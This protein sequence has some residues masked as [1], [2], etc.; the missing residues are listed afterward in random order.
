[1]STLLFIPL[2]LSHAEKIFSGKRK[3]DYIASPAAAASSSSFSSFS[4]SSKAA[5]SEEFRGRSRRGCFPRLAAP[6]TEKGGSFVRR[7]NVK[8]LNGFHFVR[9]A[10]I[11]TASHGP[12]YIQTN[13]Q[14]QE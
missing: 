3:G 12:R 10:A 11:A 1:L 4:S 7:E 2:L 5:A 13:F 14:F 6:K 9:C 8:K